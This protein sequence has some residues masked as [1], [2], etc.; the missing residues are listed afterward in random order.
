MGACSHIHV[1]TS[2][3]IPLY[4]HKELNTKDSL[5]LGP[6]VEEAMMISDA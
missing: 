3:Y 1:L 5:N 4:V 2:L 6:A